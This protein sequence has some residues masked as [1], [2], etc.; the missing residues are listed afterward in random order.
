MV[1]AFFFQPRPNCTF[2]PLRIYVAA[3]I[4]TFVNH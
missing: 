2:Y 3:N 4:R 1:T